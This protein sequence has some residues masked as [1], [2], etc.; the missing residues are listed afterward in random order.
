MKRDETRRTFPALIVA[1]LTFS[2]SFMACSNADDAAYDESQ[3]EVVDTNGITVAPFPALSFD[4]TRS[5]DGNCLNKTEWDDGDKIYIRINGEGDWHTLVY[6]DGKWAFED[7]DDVSLA[8]DDTYEAVYAPNYEIDFWERER[9]CIIDQSKSDEFLTCSGKRPIYISFERKYSRLRVHVGDHVNSVC[10]WFGDGFSQNSIHDMPSEGY[11]T[12]V[13]DDGNAYFYGTWEKGT[14]IKIKSMVSGDNAF[15]YVGDYV[16]GTIKS[17]S[18]DNKSYAVDATVES[19][20]EWIVY[21]IDFEGSNDLR[22][23]IEEGYTKVKIVGAAESAEL[24]FPAWWDDDAYRNNITDIDMSG[25]TGMKEIKSWFC[26]TNTGVRNVVL[27]KHVTKIK[28]WAFNGCTSLVSVTL[29]EDLV[30][31]EEYAFG[32][33]KSLAAIELPGGLRIIGDDA[34]DTCESLV[35]VVLPEG[36]TSVGSSAFQSCTGLKTVSLP[37]SLEAISSQA[38]CLCPALETVVCKRATPPA[39]DWT[40]FVDTPESKKL[41]VISEEAA[42]LYKASENWANAFKGGIEVLTA[43]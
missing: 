34:F 19:G 9:M 18:V 39:I 29:P 8:K 1:L 20:N 7:D 25:A 10:V 24:D 22:G 43:E 21:D 11:M 32:S 31:I 13:D 30:E 4:N 35:D 41:Y 16:C 26:T 2:F 5:V 27:P 14:D 38:F 3:S 23:Y 42:A 37:A 12:D 6:G 40:T 36:I 17:E 28:D 15:N 33:C